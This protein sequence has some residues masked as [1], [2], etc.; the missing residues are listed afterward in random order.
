MSDRPTP[1][2]PFVRSLERG[3]HVLRTLNDASSGLSLSE[4]AKRTGMTRAA[5]ASGLLA[6]MRPAASA[7]PS[8]CRKTGGWPTGFPVTARVLS[9]RP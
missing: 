9:A 7:T 4:V 6:T 1:D 2:A 5:G 3:L 8:K